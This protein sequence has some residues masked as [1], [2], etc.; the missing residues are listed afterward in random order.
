MKI[1]IGAY[2]AATRSVPVTFEHDGV[3]H[4]RN[5]NACIKADGSYDRKATTARVD[6]VASGVEHKIALGVITNPPAVDP[7]E[8]TSA[9]D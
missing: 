8:L 1:K 4:Q 7:E 5:V 3:T 9:V 2:D 6:E